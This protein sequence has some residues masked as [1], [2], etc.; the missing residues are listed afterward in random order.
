MSKLKSF[1]IKPI[2]IIANHKVLHFAN[3]YR[4]LEHYPHG[5]L[6]ALR[7]KK[8][9]RILTHFGSYEFYADY[10]GGIEQLSR[11]EDLS[12]LPVIEKDFI[13]EN[14]NT[15]KGIVSGA[16]LTSTSGS[17]GKNF[18]FYRCKNVRAAQSEA[19]A[20]FMK[21]IKN[22]DQS[23]CTIGIWGGNLQKQEHGNRWLEY[24][25][26][27]I[28]NLK[29]YPG[30]L[31]DDEVALKYIG[32][33]SAIR[34]AVLYGYP[35]YLYKI[36]ESGLKYDKPC[37]TPPVIIAS[38]EQLQDAHREV[39]EKYFDAKIY[40]RYGSCE[41]GVIAHELQDH[42]GLYSNPMRFILEEDTDGRLLITDL[43]N[44]ATPFIRYNIGDL[45]KVERSGNWY[46]ITQLNGRS[47]DV[48]ETPSGKRIPS[49]FWTIL[50]RCSGDIKE[51]QVEQID[52]THIVMKVVTDTLTQ[53]DI[54]V[55]VD[56]F[57]NNYGDEIELSMTQVQKLEAT[58]FGKLKF[59]KKYSKETD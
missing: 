1:I 53:S 15:I 21:K 29:L 54:N 6:E 56:N 5:Q 28:L 8:L 46:K 47:N 38:G 24:A 48:I 26:E 34:P 11:L 14:I 43:D 36:A 22:K 51:F 59:I 58:D 52:E 57:R 39:I 30:Y 4:K 33:I 7:L 37:Y 18:K 17:S 31:L 10:S 23:G 45:G 32:E 16:S 42:D 50:S 13:R 25:K 3:A 19:L 20:L 44:F 27:L 40:N 55:I 49:Q 9:N 2:K 12:L 41:F 35:S